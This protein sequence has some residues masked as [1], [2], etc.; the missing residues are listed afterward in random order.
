MLK[1]GIKNYVG[2]D[3]LSVKPVSNQKFAIKVESCMTTKLLA[4]A[5]LSKKTWIQTQF[6]SQHI[7]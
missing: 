7:N 5:I 2:W 1:L 4:R 3:R 6:Q